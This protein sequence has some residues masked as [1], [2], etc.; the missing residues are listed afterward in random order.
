MQ[1]LWINEPGF[2]APATGVDAL[3][4]GPPASSAGHAY[5]WP[6]RLR[7]TETGEEPVRQF[8]T[9]RGGEF[10]FAPSLPFLRVLAPPQG[11]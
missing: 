7:E 4:G 11:S 2:V 10:F 3:I 8:V 9:L 6:L 1:K 5:R